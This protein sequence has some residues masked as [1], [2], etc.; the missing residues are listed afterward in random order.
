MRASIA[1]PQSPAASRR[2]AS[3]RRRFLG[4][5]SAATKASF[6]RR[7]CP[8]AESMSRDRRVPAA[9]KKSGKEF[10]RVT[11]FL[12]RDPC[13]VALLR[14]RLRQCR[15]CA[16]QFALPLRQHQPREFSR[17]RIERRRRREFGAAPSAGAPPERRQPA[18]AARTAA[19]PVGGALRS[20]RFSVGV[21]RSC[22]RRRSVVATAASPLPRAPALTAGSVSTASTSRSRAGPRTRASHRVSSMSW[23]YISPA[24]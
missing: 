13:G 22:A 8:A 20:A 9:R 11:Q 19:K 18:R 7:A 24:A 16:Q 6:E 10:A 15:A 2:R 4:R 12:R 23:T 14:R 5:V 17:R 3:W 21:R 1:R